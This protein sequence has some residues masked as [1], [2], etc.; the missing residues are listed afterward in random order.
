MFGSGGARNIPDGFAR[1][2]AVAQF[3]DLLSRM[4]PQAAEHG[5]NLCLEPLRSQ[6][7]NFLNTVPACMEIVQGVSHAS[8][9]LTCDI[10][11]IM[12]QGRGPA[13]IALAGAS[14]RHCHIAENRDRSAPGVHGDDFT[15]FLAA[16][17]SLGYRGRISVECRFSDRAAELAGAVRVLSNQ[18]ASV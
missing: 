4:A 9:Q 3:V 14:I 8:V 17:K 13:D 7:T 18:M 16:L 6:E 1:E 15:P 5:V 12:Q 10:Y 11:H 2:D